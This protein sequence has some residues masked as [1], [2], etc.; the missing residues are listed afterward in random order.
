M[1]QKDQ[2]PC[3][4]ADSAELLFAYVDGTLEAKELAALEAHIAQCEPCH[5]MVAGQRN[6][7]Q[8]MDVWEAPAVSAD[9]NRNMHAFVAREAAKSSWATRWSAVVDQLAGLLTVKNLMVPAGAM[10]LLVAG[11]MVVDRPVQ[12]RQEPVAQVAAPQVLNEKAGMED[13]EARQIEHVVDDLEALDKLDAALKPELE[14][15]L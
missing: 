2:M 3:L 5:E 10:A 13:S 8:T 9:F 11:F 15:K 14:E 12:T 1:T 4:S 6:L 7:W